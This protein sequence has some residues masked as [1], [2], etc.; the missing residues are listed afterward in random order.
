MMDVYLSLGSNIDAQKNMQAAIEALEKKYGKLR[1]STI[2]ESEAVGFQGDNFL[3]CVVAFD[4]NNTV[5]SITALPELVEVLIKELKT[6]ED[7][8]GRVRGG[9]KFS[10]RT[11]DIDIILFGNLCG[12]YA[13][14]RIPRDEITKNAY[15]LLPL[16]EL[17]PDLKD[18]ASGKSMKELW[19]CCCLD[20]QK[21]KLWKAEFQV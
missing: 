21:Q 12:E 4:F 19:D 5:K 17:A 11:I 15:V 14:V 1:V 18:P 7:Q 16:M 10:A 9:P 13:G 20:M 3:N 2:Y 8:L 6:M